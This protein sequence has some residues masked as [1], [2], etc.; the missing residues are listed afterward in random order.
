MRINNDKLYIFIFIIFSAVYLV[1][2]ISDIHNAW[3]F[4]S[5]IN[6]TSG[7]PIAQ[8]FANY[9]CAVKLTLS[10]NAASIYN[11]NKLHG[12]QLEIF[13]STNYY[14]CGWYYP[15]TFLLFIFPFGLICYLPALFLWIS[16]TLACYL[17]VLNKI[18]S[19]RPL[20][21]FVCLAFPATFLNI[22]LGQNGFL[23]AALLGGGLLL[24]NSS[25]ILAGL[26]IGCLSYKPHLI[27]LPLLALTVGQYWRVL[28]VAIGI[29]VGLILSSLVFFGFTTWSAFFQTVSI[30]KKLLEMGDISWQMTP[31][32]FSAVMSLGYS[33]NTAYIIHVS[34]MLLAFGAVIFAWGRKNDNDLEIRS[35]ILVL[36]VLL[37]TPYLFVYDLPLLALSLAWLWK[38]GYEKGRLQGE[39]LILLITWLMPLGSLLLWNQNILDQAKLQ[40]GPIIILSCLILALWRFNKFKSI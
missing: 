20:F 27:V 28:I 31:T 6:K 10:D 11:I 18:Y 16:I 30:P 19:N 15:P 12:L 34:I 1:Q 23:S 21:L 24:L 32:F 37:F 8:D 40:V 33:I 14:G 36:A 29:S 13:G 7:K 25:P 3:D 22:M 38:E 4:N 17:F 9:W 35:A 2:Y 39:L 5:L 26:L